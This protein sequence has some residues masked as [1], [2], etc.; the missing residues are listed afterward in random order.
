M[1]SRLRTQAALSQV[2]NAL[3]KLGVLPKS[4]NPT[5]NLVPAFIRRDRPFAPIVAFQAHPFVPKRIDTIWERHLTPLATPQ[6]GP[7]GVKSGTHTGSG[8]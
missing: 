8:N 6:N 3:L 4:A 2:E 5:V 1:G 7:L